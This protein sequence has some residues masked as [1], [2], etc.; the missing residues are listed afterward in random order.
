M[1]PLAPAMFP[2]EPETPPPLPPIPADLIHP[3]NGTSHPSTMSLS[4]SSDTCSA[5]DFNFSSSVVNL[6][7]SSSRERTSSVSSVDSAGSRDKNSVQQLTSKSNI[8]FAPPEETTSIMGFGGKESNLLIPMHDLMALAPD[9]LASQLY[10]AYEGVL[11]CQEA[12]WEQLR[13]RIR[14]RP[15]E[16]RALGWDD[17]EELEEM[18]ARKKFETLVQRYRE[19]VIVFLVLCHIWL[20]IHRSSQRHAS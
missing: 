15:E 7:D 19:Y 6:D 2:S 9:T 10:R 14:N 17:D 18:Q 3:R 1:P 20:Y 13:D 11:A 4:L 12:M 8:S 5:A 16:L